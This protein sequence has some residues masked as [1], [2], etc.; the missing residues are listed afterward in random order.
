MKMVCLDNGRMTQGNPSASLG[1][2]PGC[3]CGAGSSNTPNEQSQA[4]HALCPDCGGSLPQATPKSQERKQ[5]R[6][7]LSAFV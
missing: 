7:F 3:V 2:P 4:P 5:L 1:M 6:D